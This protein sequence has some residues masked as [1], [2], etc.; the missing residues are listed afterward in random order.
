M[1][2]ES[3]ALPGQTAAI[4]EQPAL[5]ELLA[6]GRCLGERPYRKALHR[7]E[8][9]MDTPLI[10]LEHG[11][12]PR[13]QREVAVVVV[14]IILIEGDRH[15]E[16]SESDGE[17]FPAISEVGHVEPVAIVGMESVLVQLVGVYAEPVVLQAE[18][19]VLI[20]VALEKSVVGRVANRIKNG[21]FTLNGTEYTLYQNDNNNTLHGGKEGFDKKIAEKSVN[22]VVAAITDTTSLFL[23]VTV[24]LLISP[25]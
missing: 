1:G 16:L 15:R 10:W 23:I 6:V 13:H 5:E 8:L 9:E 14:I 19:P 20:D 18:I 3:L 17:P 2:A 4:G 12:E 7:S 22:A 11:P 25:S 24:L 21:R